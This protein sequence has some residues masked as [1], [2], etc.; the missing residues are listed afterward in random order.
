MAF[1]S[2][3]QG[4]ARPGP[5][6]SRRR[7]GGGPGGSNGHAPGTDAPGPR[8]LRERVRATLAATRATLAGFPRVLALVWGASKPL[9]LTLAV[10]TALAG[11]VPPAQAYTAKLLINALVRAIFIHPSHAPDQ[12]VLVI[13]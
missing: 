13:P 7:A 1:H 8:G 4:F 10:A 5:Y 11:P 6:A 3:G 12:M 9:T 2:D